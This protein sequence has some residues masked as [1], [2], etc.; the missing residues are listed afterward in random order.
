M[1]HLIKF[2]VHVW[3]F[4]FEWH[5][6]CLMKMFMATLEDKARDWYEWLEPRSLFSLKDMHQV[7]YERYKENCPSLSWDCCEQS[8]NFM[9]CLLD[10]DEDLVDMHPEDLS[11]AIQ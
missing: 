3:R 5:E 6:D 11:K 8:Q 4:K 7:F 2:H 1:L 9:Q 10:I